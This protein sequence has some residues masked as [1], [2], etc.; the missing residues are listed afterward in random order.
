MTFTIEKD[1]R[2]EA[3]HFLPH[4]EGQCKEPHGHSWVAIVGIRGKKLQRA[5]KPAAMMKGYRGA[6]P[7]RGSY[8][9][10]SKGMDGMLYDLGHLGRVLKAIRVQYLDHK[11]LNQS[12]GIL[13]P[14][15]E[16]VALFIWRK[17]REALTDDLKALGLHVAYV[18]VNE[19]C[20][21]RAIVS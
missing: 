6:R 4:H 17:V 15:S 13:S 1:I 16:E 3:A 8:S 12:L 14:T 7:W 18:K 5:E 19:T 9:F 10:D 20:T 21:G 11:H 2:F